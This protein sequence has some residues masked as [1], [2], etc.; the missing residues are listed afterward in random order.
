M[1]YK[2]FIRSNSLAALFIEPEAGW[3]AVADGDIKQLELIPDSSI[4][5][6]FSIIFVNDAS[7]GN[8]IWNG[9][10][11]YNTTGDIKGHIYNKELDSLTEGTNESF[12]NLNTA[13]GIRS[14]AEGRGTEASG[15]YSHAEGY[16]TTASGQASYAEGG[17]TEASGSYSH[18]EGYYT[19]ASGQASHVEGYESDA[20]NF[21]THAE[22]YYTTASGQASHAEGD[23]TTAS[24]QASHAEGKGGNVTL[25]QVTWYP[26]TG[27]TKL[28]YNNQNSSEFA[29][30]SAL[31]FL[32]GSDFESDRWFGNSASD[33]TEKYRLEK[34]NKFAGW[35]GR[36]LYKADGSVLGVITRFPDRSKGESGSWFIIDRGAQISSYAYV[37][38]YIKTGAAGESSH[39]EGY[40]SDAAGK[41]SHA[42]GERTRVTGTAAHGEGTKTQAYGAYSHAEGE[43]TQTL[44][45][46]SH[47][48]GKYTHAEGEYTHVEGYD[49]KAS[50][51][52]AHAEGIRSSAQGEGSHAE[53]YNCTTDGNTS[54]KEAN[55][56]VILNSINSQSIALRYV[57][58]DGQSN[59]VE[60]FNTLRTIQLK[61]T[62][63][64]LEIYLI[65]CVLDYTSNN[66]I[67]LKINS[68]IRQGASVIKYNNGYTIGGIYDV[69][70]EVTTVA[71][72]AEGKDTEAAQTASHAEGI[73]TRADGD[74]THAEGINSKALSNYAHAEGV[75]TYINDYSE[76]SHTEGFETQSNSN[77]S[78][79]E[80]IKTVING[81]AIGSHAEGFETLVEGEYSH[82]EGVKTET[83]NYAEHAQGF[84]NVS[85]KASDEY[86]NKGNTLFSVGAGGNIEVYKGEPEFIGY[87]K[88]ISDLADQVNWQYYSGSD[89]TAQLKYCLIAERHE[90]PTPDIADIENLVGSQ[91]FSD[92]EKKQ[93]LG[94]V[95][96]AARYDQTEPEKTSARI[97]LALDKQVVVSYDPGNAISCWRVEKSD[98]TEFIYT[99]GEDRANALEIMQNG[100]IYVRG[101]GNFNGD[102]INEAQTLQ[103]MLKNLDP[104]NLNPLFETISAALNNLND[105]LIALDTVVSATLVNHENRLQN[106][107]TTYEIPKP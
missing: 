6:E 43:Q 62:N 82:A 19:T 37:S 38:A 41:F 47:S 79:A 11:I 63:N 2:Q 103:Q 57:S 86:G 33:I 87:F 59:F 48:E 93:Y 71:A 18:A 29:S 5:S 28:Y 76:G 80:G 102:I 32:A 69:F 78:H 36:T 96:A 51:L 75:N 77:Y 14:H 44:A 67:Y 61:N 16:Y 7:Y 94:T 83:K 17:S 30:D 99:G 97:Y 60:Y 66:Y 21:Y 81:D 25:F 64:K 98:E 95:I 50:G 27:N 106:L 89:K 105:K 46:G 24:G 100:D 58:G 92:D 10:Y 1:N 65:N 107:E 52:Y 20:T 74:A 68:D 35:I 40:L 23:T 84:R 39:S 26:E 15:S 54:Y 73:N 88:R 13:S 91:L 8:Y 45:F 12:G 49:T 34:T 70:K 42:E 56:K 4:A 90:M 22:G 3:E 72:H 9:G 55:H 101:A 104:S 53:G 31:N 85:H